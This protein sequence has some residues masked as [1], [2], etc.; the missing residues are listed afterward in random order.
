[1]KR[2]MNKTRYEREIKAFLDFGE[3]RLDLIKNITSDQL[4]FTRSSTSKRRSSSSAFEFQSGML[5]RID[6][7]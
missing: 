7:Q 5:M 4:P 6:L 2:D 3:K 1:M